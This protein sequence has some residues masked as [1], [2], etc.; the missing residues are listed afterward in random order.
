MTAESGSAAGHPLDAV[1]NAMQTA[2]GALRD[3]AHDAS[4]KVQ[5]VLP[6]VSNFVSRGAYNG[7]YYASYGVVFPTLFLCHV[8]PGGKSVASG[9]LDGAAAASDYIRGL[10]QS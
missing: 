7:S 4:T 6:R 2:A 10:K 9:I 3:G 8:I 5:E 1:A